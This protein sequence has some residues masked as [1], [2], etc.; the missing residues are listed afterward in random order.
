MIK[1]KIIYDMFYKEYHD[2]K[3]NS[4]SSQTYII[5]KPNLSQIIRLRNARTGQ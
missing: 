5:Q 1:N 3:N 2:K 4:C